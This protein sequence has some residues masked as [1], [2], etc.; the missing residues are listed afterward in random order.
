MIDP[1]DLLKFGIKDST[2]IVYNPSYDTLFAE[3]VKPDLSQYEK[4]I[5]TSSG[6]IS[7]D[8]GIFTGR[9][10]KDK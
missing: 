9:S 7:V 3:E 6:A 10:P 4:G 2:E 1:H 5:I 8:T